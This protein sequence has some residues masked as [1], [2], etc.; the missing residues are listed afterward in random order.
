MGLFGF[1]KNPD[2]KSDK[3]I[4]CDLC[5]EEKSKFFSTTLIDGHRLCKDCYSARSFAKDI[6]YQECEWNNWRNWSLVE[7]TDCAAYEAYM[8]NTLVQMFEETHTFGHMAIDANHG[9]FRRTGRFRSKTSEK[10][11]IYSFACMQDYEFGLFHTVSTT[12]Y[13]DGSRDVYEDP[14]S[15][16]VL[17]I[18]MWCPHLEIVFEGEPMLTEAWSEEY[19][20][21]KAFRQF[22]SDAFRYYTGRM[23]STGSCENNGASQYTFSQEHVE[24]ISAQYERAR[25]L[26]LISDMSEVTEEYLDRMYQVLQEAYRQENP[27]GFRTKNAYEI[28]EAYR[29]LKALFIR[30]PAE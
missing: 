29:A 15:T 17:V 10:D 6:S 22:F 7:F 14:M 11:R 3:R 1:G 5:H 2:D 19:K 24:Q 13:S 21:F 30:Q 18:R 20:D 26:F 12:S 28:D 4:I 27:F 25:N 9:L 8:Q 23:E 16:P